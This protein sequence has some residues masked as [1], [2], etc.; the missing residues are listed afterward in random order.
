MKKIS[1][2]LFFIALAF[3]ILSIIL[4]IVFKLLSF[5]NMYATYIVASCALLGGL[6]LV[7]SSVVLFVR[8]DLAPVWSEKLLFHLPE[9][10]VTGLVMIALGVI[11]FWGKMIK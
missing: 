4:L 9:L 1:T 11:L 3:I 5:T 6:G 10:I 8:N 7:I 2:V